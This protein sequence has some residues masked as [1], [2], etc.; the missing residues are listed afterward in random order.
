MDIN[1]DLGSKKDQN[2]NKTDL[3]IQVIR[4]NQRGVQHNH[5]PWVIIV[6]NYNHK[7]IFVLILLSW[8]LSTRINKLKLINK[9][10]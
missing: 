9:N 4:H 6:N 3:H 8:I 5:Y 7:K 2:L 1:E 10:I